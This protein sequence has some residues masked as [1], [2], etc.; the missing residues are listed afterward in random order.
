[1][2]VPEGSASREN[3]DTG[4]EQETAVFMYCEEEKY[5]KDG[6]CLRVGEQCRCPE[7]L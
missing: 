4:C 2:T 5:S 3:K 7:G 6:C 1:M